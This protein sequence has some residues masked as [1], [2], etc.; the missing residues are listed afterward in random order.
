[1]FT[2]DDAPLKAFQ[3][4]FCAFNLPMAVQPA[5][6]APEQAAVSSPVHNNLIDT[7][8][9]HALPRRLASGEH[10]L[11]E[12]LTST[13]EQRFNQCQF[14]RSRGGGLNWQ[15][16]RRV[17]CGLG[18]GAIA[19]Q[20]SNGCTPLLVLANVSSASFFSRITVQLMPSW[21]M[22][23][24]C[25]SVTRPV[26]IDSCNPRRQQAAV[27]LNS[28]GKHL[29]VG[30]FHRKPFRYEHVCLSKPNAVRVASRRYECVIPH[31]EFCCRHRIGN[32]SAQRAE[33]RKHI[34]ISSALLLSTEA[35]AP[36][37]PF[38]FNKQIIGFR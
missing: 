9:C 36:S 2:T 17:S 14:R 4:I 34:L 32:P 18:L 33:C 21:P 27:N 6:A 12:P 28:F 26:A 3:T 24:S 30:R 37:S 35:H 11:L 38:P 10:S 7:V 31:R 13:T 19:V 20:F 15:R 23:Y 22:R 8:A 1:M 29:W 25:V 5:T 16:R